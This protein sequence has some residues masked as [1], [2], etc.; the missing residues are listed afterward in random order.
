MIISIT[1]VGDHIFFVETHIKVQSNPADIA[2]AL[3]DG[4]GARV[5]IG[6]LIGGGLGDVGAVLTGHAAT[7]EGN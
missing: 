5:R 4:V 2:L 6:W 7:A 1:F 3:A